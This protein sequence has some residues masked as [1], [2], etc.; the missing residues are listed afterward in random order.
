MTSFTV[1]VHDS[2]LAERLLKVFKEAGL[3]VTENTD[4]DELVSH[5]DALA[6]LYPDKSPEEIIG[7]HLS[8]ARE[9]AGL[10]QT[11]LA[12]KIGTQRQA[13]SAMENGKRPISRAMAKKLEKA[14]NVPYK[15]FL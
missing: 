11:Q 8:A 7:L 1:N 10:T 4:D 15:A 14:L 12:E 9:N 5:E 3:E 6:Y 2:A 13:I